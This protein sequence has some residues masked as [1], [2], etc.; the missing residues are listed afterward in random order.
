MELHIVHN[1]LDNSSTPVVFNLG[2]MYAKTSY[3]NQN[4]TK[5]LLEP[6]SSSDP[7][8]HKDLWG[9]SMPETSSIISLTGQTHINNWLNI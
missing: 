6:W 7:R 3:I 4:E 1:F 8:S 2:Y 9:A 5:E